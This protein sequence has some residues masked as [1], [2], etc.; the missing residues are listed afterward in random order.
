LD[1]KKFSF[2]DFI[3][4]FVQTF[5]NVKNRQTIDDGKTGGY[6][7]LQMLFLDYVK[8]KCGDNNEFRYNKLFNF[9]NSL[10]AYWIK[11]IEQFVPSTTLWQGG[12][13]VENSLFH[14]DKFVYKHNTDLL[15]IKSLPEG[16]KGGGE[17][18]LGDTGPTNLKNNVSDI[19]SVTT[20]LPQ[21]TINLESKSNFAQLQTSDV[22]VY[23]SLNYLY[24]TP[25][26][27]NQGVNNEIKLLLGGLLTNERLIQPN[28]LN[29]YQYGSNLE[30]EINS[31][32]ILVEATKLIEDENT[33]PPWGYEFIL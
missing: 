4:G 11:I 6:P 24:Q 29:P 9:A 12:V 19:D 13:R 23:P 7:T 1:A 20:T 3:D 30:L 21:T 32:K 15:G 31:G 26:T 28:N 8:K 10:G 14:R 25:N 33:L 18:Y 2:K 27:S 5:I 22:S 17:T 16:K